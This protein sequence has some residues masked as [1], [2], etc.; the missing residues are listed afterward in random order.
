MGASASR[1][2][3]TISFALAHAGEMLD[4]A[5]DAD[6]DVGL[7]LHGFAGLADL[8]GVRTPAG[9]DYGAGGSY[10]CS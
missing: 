4:R 2:I 10:G 8:L 5:G 7:G 9:V 3:A 1:L 6:G